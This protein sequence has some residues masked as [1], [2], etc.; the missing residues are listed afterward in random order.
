MPIKA[1]RVCHAQRGL[2]EHGVQLREP[3]GSTDKETI[4]Y[5]GR[6]QDQDVAVKIFTAIHDDIR[7]T[8]GAYGAFKVECEKTMILSRRQPARWC[9]SRVRR[10]RLARRHAIEC[11]ANS[12]RSDL[13]PF[14]II[15]RAS[16]GSLDSVLK[17][18]RNMPGFDRVSLME[19]VSNATEGIKE[20][21][22]HMV[23][24]RDIKPQNIL[25]FGPSEGKIADFGVARWRSRVT[26]ATPCC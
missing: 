14:M 10:C 18:Y 13:V 16:Y 19:A 25:I 7:D 24:H 11:C 6:Y 2:P 5:A 17:R 15:E 22:D 8:V 12:S 9:R 3:I 21:H 20:A 23:A 4:V 26:G 1:F